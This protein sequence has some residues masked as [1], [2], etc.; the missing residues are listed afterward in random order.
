MGF[1]RAAIFFL[2]GVGAAIGVYLSGLITSVPHINFASI[3]AHAPSTVVSP[4]PDVGD[5]PRGGITCRFSNYGISN[6]TDRLV[7]VTVL[8]PGGIPTGDILPEHS[9][10]TRTYLLAPGETTDDPHPVVCGDARPD[11]RDPARAAAISPRRT[12][13]PPHILPSDCYGPDGPCTSDHP[14]ID[15]DG[16]ER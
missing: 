15:Q 8:P 2:L 4:P 3:F 6:H 13:I 5:D 1:L 12:G 14:D 16:E 11:L 10:E 9:I 7:L